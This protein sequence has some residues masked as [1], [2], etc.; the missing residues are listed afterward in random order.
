MPESQ[1]GVRV[2]RPHPCLAG[3]PVAPLFSERRRTPSL[4]KGESVSILYGELV[5]SFSPHRRKSVPSLSLSLSLSLVY[6]EKRQTLSRCRWERVSPVY[7]EYAD[8]FL[9]QGRVAPVLYAEEKVFWFCLERRQTPSSWIGESVV[10]PIQWAVIPLP[11]D[12]VL[13]YS[14]RRQTPS[15]EKGE[16]VSLLYREEPLSFSVQMREWLPFSSIHSGG[17]L[18]L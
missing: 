9:M 18:R 8:S 2:N 14:E 16:S 1:T 17:G 15:L 10:P 7:R 13:F 5:V 11:S 3:P 4:E 12:D 6:T